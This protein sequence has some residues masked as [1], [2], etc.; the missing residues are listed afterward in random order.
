MDHSLLGK[1]SL[2]KKNDSY[3]LDKEITYLLTFLRSNSKHLKL[4]DPIEFLASFAFY[5]TYLAED[6]HTLERFYRLKIPAG[7]PKRLSYI[8]YQFFKAILPFTGRAFN[9]DKNHDKT[10][11]C[12]VERL[13]LL[14]LK[15]EEGVSGD[16]SVILLEAGRPYGPSIGGSHEELDLVTYPERNEMAVGE[17][18]YDGSWFYKK[19]DLV[20]WYEDAANRIRVEGLN[21]V[22]TFAICGANADVMEK[23]LRSMPLRRRWWILSLSNYK[24][25]IKIDP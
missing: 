25:Q 12:L 10:R 23:H 2:R 22:H 1:L 24:V 3:L 9:R 21:E 14:V 4:V 11:G 15:C 6:E 5:G 20:A 18:K 8:H 17:C 19:P 7:T 13:A 16:C